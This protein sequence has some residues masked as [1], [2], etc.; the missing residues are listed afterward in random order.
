MDP[1]WVLEE[2]SYD[3]ND[4]FVSVAEEFLNIVS[5]DT[6]Q[7][8]SIDDGIRTL[9]IIE[10]ARQSSSSDKVIGLDTIK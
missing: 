6:A 2:F 8:C 4:M 1:D 10:A 7:S 5:G 3:R 9:Q